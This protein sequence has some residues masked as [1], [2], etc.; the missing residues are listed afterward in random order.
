MWVRFGF[1]FEFGLGLDF[2]VTVRLNQGSKSDLNS[3]NHLSAKA[4]VCHESLQFPTG[5]DPALV[6]NKCGETIEENR[7]NT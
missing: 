3:V 2:G 7:E 6:W 4:R 1:E 5:D